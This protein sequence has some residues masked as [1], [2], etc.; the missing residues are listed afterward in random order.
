M[1]GALYLKNYLTSDGMLK[2]PC[3]CYLSGNSL[4]INTTEGLKKTVILNLLKFV[5]SAL[6][7]FAKKATTI[8]PGHKYHVLHVYYMDIGNV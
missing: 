2:L 3:L 7:I 5:H 8:K 1:S 4:Q 6:L